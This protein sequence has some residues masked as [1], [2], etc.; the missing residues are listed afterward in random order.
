MRM[1]SIIGNPYVWYVGTCDEIVAAFSYLI[2][3]LKAIT[4]YGMEN[5]PIYEIPTDST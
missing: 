3:D 1:A 5:R 2:A 4:A